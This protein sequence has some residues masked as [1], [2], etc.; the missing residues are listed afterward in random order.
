MRTAQAELI[1]SVY[2]PRHLLKLRIPKL[3][4]VQTEVATAIDV[5]KK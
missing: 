1:S 4:T 2:L 5:I 3:R